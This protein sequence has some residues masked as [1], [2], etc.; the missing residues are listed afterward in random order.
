MEIIYGI[1]KGITSIN[2]TEIMYY[3]NKS[4]NI[5]NLSDTFF[6]DICHVYPGY[7]NDIILEDRIED[8]FL[9]YSV[10]EEGCIYKKFDNNYYTFTCECKIKNNINGKI[11]E[12]KFEEPHI[13][14]NNFEVL[15]C[16]N[17]VFSFENKINNIG[18]WIFTFA[19]GGL[20]PLFLHFII[21]GI[22]PIEDLILNEMS[23]YGYIKTAR[24][25]DRNTSIKIR[26]IK[27]K[28]T[29]K[30]RRK[31]K[32]SE[33]GEKNEEYNNNY[34]NNSNNSESQKNKKRKDFKKTKGKEINIINTSF[35]PQKSKSK[36]QNKRKS[37]IIKSI[38]EKN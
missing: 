10:C 6:N 24:K 33:K 13:K 18:F 8:F 9:N 27:G 38:S 14:T 7:E 17:L 23:E 5:F 29:T 34:E 28:K 15:K 1:K 20:V 26:R 2:Y 21:T 30:K 35:P 25:V 12:I 31:T 4:I 3:Q 37:V 36:K 11:N 16:T 22:K 19:L 32:L